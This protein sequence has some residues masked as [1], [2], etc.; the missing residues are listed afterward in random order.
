M[1]QVKTFRT[2]EQ[3][4][5]W[6]EKNKNKMQMQEIFINNGYGVEYRKKQII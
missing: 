2:R 1:W 4:K 5:Q 6:Q 3:L